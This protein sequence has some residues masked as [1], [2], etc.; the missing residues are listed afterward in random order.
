MVERGLV[1]RGVEL[2]AEAGEVGVA[3]VVAGG[4]DEV[5]GFLGVFAGFGLVAVGEVERGL[6]QVVVGEV[7]AHAG[8]GG[9]F[10]HFVEVVLGAAGEEAERE[11]FEL[12]GA[13]EAVDGGGEVDR[14]AGAGEGEVVEGDVE[15]PVVPIRDHQGLGGTA[16]ELAG[17][18]NG[19]LGQ[20]LG[21]LLQSHEGPIRISR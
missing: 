5:G 6:F 7:E 4:L 20:A 12:S 3:A 10:V 15:E 13:A 19:D 9:D 11:E 14:V 1:G 17:D 21:D 2:L 16:A 18:Y 8:T